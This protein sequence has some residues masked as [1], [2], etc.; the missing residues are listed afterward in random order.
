[1]IGRQV[2]GIPYPEQREVYAREARAASRLARDADACALG[3][4]HSGA[5]VRVRWCVVYSCV[6]LY[7]KVRRGGVLI[8]VARRA[9]KKKCVCARRAR[10]FVCARDV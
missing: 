2:D 10:D 9:P 8:S 1:M 6:H 5:S 7:L 4:P 3:V